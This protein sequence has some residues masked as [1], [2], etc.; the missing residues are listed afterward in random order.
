M[1]SGRNQPPETSEE[2]FTKQEEENK[3]KKTNNKRS[4]W[5]FVV[6]FFATTVMRL[7]VDDLSHNISTGKAKLF[8]HATA[9]VA[10]AKLGPGLTIYL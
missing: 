1:S 9:N 6:V 10:I 8:R 2:K 5:N 3:Q 4:M 7:T